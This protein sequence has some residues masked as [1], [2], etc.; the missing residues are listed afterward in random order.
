MSG[1][2][3]HNDSYAEAI[4]RQWA[5]NYFLDKKEPED[6]TG[7]ENHDTPSIGGSRMMHRVSTKQLLPMPSA[8]LILD[9]QTD[10]F[11]S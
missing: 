4:H 5:A 9:R 11:V 3:K 10:D 1:V 6:C 8:L 7:A 2:G